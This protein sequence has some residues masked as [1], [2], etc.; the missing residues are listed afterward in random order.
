[1]LK[2]LELANFRN[3]D[4]ADF[5]FG[6]TIIFI[7]PNGIGKTNVIEAVYL[8]STGRSWRTNHDGETIKWGSDFCT[9]DAKLDD[10]IKALRLVMQKSQEGLP[11][12]KTIKIND[13]KNKLIE[14]LGKLPTVLFS[15]EEIDLADGAPQLR[16]RFLDILLCQTDRKYTIAL[17]DLAKILKNRN[18][19]LF[20][21]KIGK[22]KVDELDF[23]DLKLVE[24]GKFIIKK[25]E[26][27]IKA[28]NNKIGKVYAE[29]SGHKE[30]FLL[31]YHPS[32]AAENFDEILVAARDREIEYTST[33][34]GPHRDDFSFLLEDRDIATFGSRGEFRSAILALK[35]GEL[36]FLR[37]TLEEEPILLLDDIFSELDK[38]RRMHLAKIVESAQTIITTT[39]LDHIEKGLRDKAKIVE[40]K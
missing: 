31:K 8:L 1:M 12:I 2:H 37:N 20:Y 26:E 33:I 23:W 15:P 10:D 14:L 35:V 34:H 13:V 29:I 38:N 36:E 39:D 24:I 16:R 21:I 17:L 5:D 27:V 9:I 4:K 25:R 22:S 19:L 40:L 18:K 28:L 11:L 32:A 3:Y 6:K 30:K 7:G